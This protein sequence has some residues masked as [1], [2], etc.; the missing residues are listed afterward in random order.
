[1]KGLILERYQ[2]RVCLVTVLLVGLFTTNSSAQTYTVINTNDSGAGSLREAIAN[3]NA[4]KAADSI[5]FD[6]A[7]SSN[8]IVLNSGLPSITSDMYIDAS[9]QSGGVSIAGERLGNEY[10]MTFGDSG[11]G[12][13]AETVI[14]GLSFKDLVFAVGIDKKAGQVIFRN[15]RFEEIDS[16]A[17]YSTTKNRLELTVDSC[18]FSNIG[19]TAIYIEKVADPQILNSTFSDLNQAIYISNSVGLSIRSNVFTS[20]E[21]G[22]SIADKCEKGQLLNNRF[23]GIDGSAIAISNASNY[24]IKENVITRSGNAEY[25][26]IALYDIKTLNVYD[27]TLSN[28]INGIVMGDQC[29]SGEVIN[30][31]LDSISGTAITLSDGSQFDIINNTI[32]NGIAEGENASIGLLVNG[33]NN[34]KVKENA[35]TNADDGMVFD[36]K[37]VNIEIALNDIKEISGT[38]ISLEDIVNFTIVDN[39]MANTFS[40]ENSLGAKAIKVSSSRNTKITQN[41]VS[42]WTRGILVDESSR[43]GWIDSNTIDSIVYEAVYLLDAEDYSVL[44]N[45]IKNYFQDEPNTSNTAI[46]A[47]NSYTSYIENN[48][49]KYSSY[50]ILLD[51]DCDE[52]QIEKNRLDSL[53]ATAISVSNSTNFNV[54]YNDVTS[55]QGNGIYLMN[56]AIGQI[57]GNLIGTDT[58]GT[59]L[60]N[61]GNGIMMKDSITN[62][63]ISENTIGESGLS[64]I[65]MDILDNG[66]WTANILNNHVGI[67][68]NLT[69]SLTNDKS[70][71]ELDTA[72]NTNIYQNTIAYNGEYGIKL[73]HGD[74]NTFSQNLIY[75]NPEKP[76]YIY[77]ASDTRFESWPNNS[78]LTPS[79]AAV[80]C[81]G[82]SCTVVVKSERDYD[83]IELFEGDTAT[84]DTYAYITDEFE[85]EQNDFWKATFSWDKSTDLNFRATAT[86]K[87]GSTSE[88]GWWCYLV[89]DTLDHRS[90]SFREALTCA[91]YDVLNN[92]IIFQMP[93]HLERVIRPATQYPVIRHHITVTP[94]STD[95]ITFNSING[96]GFSGLVFD[97]RDSIGETI[98]RDFTIE[99]F[100]NGIHAKGYNSLR[101]EDLIIRY[102]VNDGVKIEADSINSLIAENNYIYSNEG[103]G[104]SM[105]TGTANYVSATYNKLYEN[106]RAGMHYELNATES[107]IANNLIY[108]N[109]A[110]GINTLGGK[111]TNLLHNTVFNHP[112][113]GIKLS[114]TQV[115]SVAQNLIGFNRENAA[116]A[117]SMTNL[118][119]LEIEGEQVAQVINN[120]IVNSQGNGI[121]ITGRNTSIAQ[122]YVGMLS[123]LSPLGNGGNGI[124]GKYATQLTISENFIGNNAENGIL[125]CDSSAITNNR[126][127]GVSLTQQ[128]ANAGA[129]IRGGVN[130]TIQQN[131]FT[132][133]EGGGVVVDTSVVSRDGS[134]KVTSILANTFTHNTTA[135]VS[136]YNTRQVVIDNNMINYTDSGIV[137]SNHASEVEITNN[138]VDSTASIAMIVRNA[139]DVSIEANQIVSNPQEAI[140]IENVDVATIYNNLIGTDTL[141]SSLGNGGNG[142]ALLGA[143]STIDIDNNTIADCGEA[144]IYLN[145]SSD[146]GRVT[147]ANNFIGI[148]SNLNDSLPNGASGIILDTAWNSH[149]VDN[150]IAYNHGYGIKLNHGSGNTF[151]R[152]LIYDNQETPI[153]VYGASDVTLDT[154]ANNSIFTPSVAAVNCDGTSCTVVVKSEAA[155]E[156]IELFEGDTSTWDTHT[157]ITD[158][159]VNESNHFWKATFDWDKTSNLNFRATATDTTGSTSQIGWWCYLVTDTLDQRSGS[160]REAL[161]CAN[162][163]ALNNLMVFDMPNHTERTFRPHSQYPEISH[164]ITINPD[165]TEH[166]VWEGA[167]NAGFDGLVFNGQDTDGE[168]ILENIVITGFE[169]GIRSQGSNSLMIDNVVI[170]EN[171]RAGL[172]VS[173]DIES[174]VTLNSKVYANDSAGIYLQSGK[175]NQVALYGNEIYLNNSVGL[176]YGLDAA[177]SEISNN[178]I[179]N[180]KGEGIYTSGG[181][182]GKLINNT[183]FGN[184]LSGIRVEH[185]VVDSIAL[186]RIGFSR[187]TTDLDLDTLAFTD[188]TNFRLNLDTMSNLY[189]MQIASYGVGIVSEN[190]I[191]GSDESGILISGGNA[192]IINNHIGML[193]DYTPMGNGGH[194]ISGKH[195]T[196]LIIEN[197]YI[198]NNTGHGILGCD[199]SQILDNKIG[200]ADTLMI[201]PNH[202]QAIRGGVS[203]TI[204]D[205]FITRNSLGGITIDTSVVTRKGIGRETRIANN[206]ITDNGGALIT[207][208]NVYQVAIADNIINRADSGIVIT[209][210][211]HDVTIAY[212]DIDSILGTSILASRASLLTIANNKIVSSLN[213]GITLDDIWG[214]EVYSNILGTDSLGGILGNAGNAI[215]ILG[216]SSNLTLDGNM[217]AASGNSG[218]YVNLAQDTAHLTIQNNYIGVHSEVNSFD[219]QNGGDGIT[220]DT[221][222]N[223]TIVG[224]TIGQN[225]GSGIDLNHGSGNTFSRNKI[226]NNGDKPIEIIESESRTYWPNSSVLTPSIAG[227]R[228]DNNRCTVTVKSEADYDKFEL[229]TSLRASTNALDFV[230]DD[231][232]HRGSGFWE[233]TFDWTSPDSLSFVVSATTTDK[234]TSELGR[235]CLVVT[236]THNAG[237][238]SLRDAIHCANSSDDFSILEIDLTHN[239]SKVIIPQSQLPDIT[240]PLSFVV[241]LLDSITIDGVNIPNANGLVFSGNKAGS[242]SEVEGII[243]ENFA[244]GIV[245]NGGDGAEVRN[246][247]VRGNSKNGIL[248]S[249]NIDSLSVVNT[250]AYGNGANG[251]S[252]EN[253]NA[254]SVAISQS[255]IHHN[256]ASGISYQANSNASTLSDN[257]LH[258]N[259]GSGISTSGGKLGTVSDNEIYSNTVSGI[260]MANTTIGSVRNNR[261]GAD[262]DGEMLANG[263]GMEIS[264]SAAS[265]IYQNEIVASTGSGISTTSTNTTIEANYIGMLSD[266]TPLANGSHGIAGSGASNLMIIGN[267]IGGN[268]G[269][270]ILGCDHSV[271]SQNHIGKLDSIGKVVPGN[272]GAG[273]RGGAYELIY[274]NTFVNNAEAGIVST[275]DQNRISECLFYGE[276]PLAISLPEGA[277]SPPSLTGSA[278]GEDQIII[279]GSATGADSVEVFYSTPQGQT[280]LSFVGRVKTASDGAW[281]M[282]IPS[283]PHYSAT[284]ANFYSATATDASGRTSALSE[285]SDF[286]ESICNLDHYLPPASR[287]EHFL[288]AGDFKRVVGEGEDLTYSWIHHYSGTQDSVYSTSQITEFYDGGLY[289]L[290]VKDFKCTVVD[291]LVLTVLS[292]ELGAGFLMSTIAGVGDQIVLVENSYPEPDS[293]EWDFGRAQAE[294]LDGNPVL[295]FYDTGYYEIG[296]MAYLGTCDAWMTRTIHITEESHASSDGFVY[297]YSIKSVEAF[298]VPVQDQLNLTV[299]VTKTTDL[300]IFLVDVAGNELIQSS[301]SDVSDEYQHTMNLQEFDPGLYYVSVFSS[302]GESRV[303]K[304]VKQDK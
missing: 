174:L 31:V 235:S 136:V 131:M 152:N 73:Q 50:G 74:R 149:L 87:N 284:G 140:L 179:N 52:T 242:K 241:D 15:C 153:H 78:I 270:G 84:W 60:G 125:G 265:V 197:N 195:A 72:W 255:E 53:S 181:R 71:I 162:Y 35:I 280:A 290:T 114:N 93:D 277:L 124:S 97:G 267:F 147:I 225:A 173:S 288:C 6:L 44:N 295:T 205:N 184:T 185:S 204:S 215:S 182:L 298:P 39:Y 148:H 264:G 218:I 11:G 293:V 294:F 95:F 29:A 12:G 19:K 207:V 238:G 51:E 193:S 96:T 129:G 1:M 43:T 90:G 85:N 118:H 10:A 220:L 121:V 37:S 258:A 8:T 100:D 130:S 145:L 217:I 61:N 135:S 65:Y 48:T 286:A 4:T 42:N 24:D 177:D 170:K 111:L 45:D 256:A 49:I 228:F 192:T 62:I 82:D 115:D 83:K 245:L 13:Q 59:R 113:S 77:G 202:S 98:L 119:G 108:S 151:S 106:L 112:L 116:S 274:E 201:F 32:T 127:G 194:G 240:S 80:A 191:V 279:N 66:T 299:E 171:S 20:N 30:N 122:N 103:A 278:P 26:P 142:I 123:D 36:Q 139:T 281:Q 2:L 250:K 18:D 76:I 221:A 5:V 75:R 27:N 239:L 259:A 110:E 198:G 196:N 120:E 233:A 230:T 164:H 227:V 9:S 22:I 263:V 40:D 86:D 210:N 244:N 156:K 266:F 92:E 180:N 132:A 99:G 209:D 234:N 302:N 273:L 208:A 38:G 143:S 150:R 296:L 163:D 183:I 249:G 169:N 246:S 231:F 203:S 91:N 25:P 64:G 79:V 260:K 155:Y 175:S 54:L 23:D 268:N 34:L 102:S 166:I 222:W 7:G 216:S 141:A 211:A 251:I 253:I 252:I 158:D 224:N 41:D 199:S 81:D 138:K 58:L 178:Q 254:E 105:L 157:Y 28:T 188:T 189:G 301:V 282:T 229:F 297:P 161:T 236:N 212:N 134:G 63:E 133:N 303:L 283:G 275:S 167:N 21:Q 144:G 101:L 94:D 46:K 107:G 261:I 223:V 243:I 187:D 190:E 257:L 213:D 17:I 109:G 159:F 33:S 226:Y 287:G 56:T 104:L 47:I 70:G 285:R 272:A 16:I 126:I 247:I 232:A 276:Q 248:V 160:F 154:W 69:D 289:V 57:S 117:E 88:I 67:H 219:M 168:T 214:G 300:T 165:S 68:S 146:P 200:G 269:D 137:V 237:S 14:S 291:T 176:Y 206:I 55:S 172:K 3:A 292:D 271:I 304:I 128:F 89:I 186:N 262:L